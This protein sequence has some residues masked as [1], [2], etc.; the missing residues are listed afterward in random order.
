MP[1]PIPRGSPITLATARITP[2]PTI[3]FAMPPPAS[4]GGFGV[5]VR[6]SMLTEPIPLITRYTKMAS[7][8]TST[9][10]AAETANA[11]APWLVMRRQRL[12]SCGAAGDTELGTYPRSS[13]GDA[14][15]Q[16]PRQ[17]VDDESHDEK[18]QPYFHQGAEIQ[19]P[20]GLGKLV[21]DDTGHGVA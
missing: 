6:K 19:I 7:K 3:P 10:T 15:D 17:G 13:A 18:R 5:L 21:G 9:R 16:Q 20:R 4:P 11:V 1:E 12:T 2:V 14:P 8:G